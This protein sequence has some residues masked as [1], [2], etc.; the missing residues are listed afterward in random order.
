MMDPQQLIKQKQA[1]H[2]DAW[3]L[4]GLVTKILLPQITKLTMMYPK[5]VFAWTMILNKLIRALYSPD[6]KDNWLDIQ[7]Y[8]QL[9]LNDLGEK[10]A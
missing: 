9:V 4:Y 2:G 8:A 10:N 1:T 7:G 5:Y 6:L 3:K